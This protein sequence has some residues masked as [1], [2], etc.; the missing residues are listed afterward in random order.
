MK[1]I[2]I[3]GIGKLTEI[4]DANGYRGKIINITPPDK[5]N[6]LRE[7]GIVNDFTMLF[8]S[9]LQGT[10]KEIGRLFLD[11]NYEPGQGGK[12][13]KNGVKTSSRVRSL[14]TF[15]N[16]KFIK[17]Y[18]PFFIKNVNGV[19]LCTVQGK[20][21]PKYKGSTQ[22]LLKNLSI[23][24]FKKK[25][26]VCNP[27]GSVGNKSE[28]TVMNNGRLTNEWT[29]TLVEAFGKKVQPARDAE[30]LVIKYLKKYYD[31]VN[32]YESDKDKQMNGQD[33]G[34]I[35]DFYGKEYFIDVKNTLTEYGE[36]KVNTDIDGWLFKK[37]DRIYHVNLKTR[38]C[39]SYFVEDMRKFL[40]NKNLINKGEV[41]FSNKG[42]KNI[43]FIHR[44]RI[45]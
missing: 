25:G 6:H 31:V 5:S 41:T 39:H 34:V 24:P 43:K 3:K 23:T 45:K 10:E 4:D 9:G 21:I 33:I 1:P 36:L 17:A 40:A 38:Y 32:D 13:F 18:A 37:S 16:K 19:I 15:V 44:V 22:R 26:K 28:K 29:K 20:T 14:K 12:D 8:L 27:N 42:Q 2:E 7:N 11:P 35:K 30:L